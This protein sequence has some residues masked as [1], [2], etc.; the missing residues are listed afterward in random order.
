MKWLG[1]AVLALVLLALAGILLLS[2][3]DLGRFKSTIESEASRLGGR[4]VTINGPVHIGLSLSPTLVAEKITVANAGW[5]S[6]PALATAEHAEIRVALL[7]LFQGRVVPHLIELDGATLDLENDAKGRANWRL[8]GDVPSIDGKPHESAAATDYPALFSSLGTVQVSRLDV[9]YHD[10]RTRVVTTMK[11]DEARFVPDAS[12]VEI[13]LKGTLD[14]SLIALSGVVSGGEDRTAFDN[15]SFTSGKTSIHGNLV[16]VGKPETGYRLDGKLSGNEFDLTPIFDDGADKSH[17]FGRTPLPFG[18]LRL[19]D[20]DLVVEAARLNYR[21]LAFSNVSAPI[22]I[23]RGKLTAPLKGL[24][25]GTDVSFV[26]TADGA[27]YMAGIEGRS[28]G[29]DLGSLLADLKLTTLVAAKGDFALKVSGRG[30]SVH[31]IA[32]TLNGQ[33]EVAASDGTIGTRTFELVASDLSRLIIPQGSSRN[34]TNLACFLSRFDFRDGMGVS[35]AFAFQTSDI[36]TIGRGG[37]DLRAETVD[38]LLQPKPLDPSLLSLSTP[39]RVSGR[40]DDPQIGLDTFGL[41]QK[42]AEVAGSAALTGG[43]GAILPLVSFGNAAAK[44]GNCASLVAEAAKRGGIS[45][46]VERG[47]AAAGGAVDSAI[48]GV[49][50]FFNEIGKGIGKVLK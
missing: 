27:S 24:Y 47:G 50:S 21:G 7:P 2:T 28:T 20:A 13:E 36:I 23:V 11:L 10:A 31:D 16:L 26:V 9:R 25:R 40:L 38:M 19:I 42:V 17:V 29:F 37:L 1:R 33:T 6:A 4:T 49:G 41:A 35:K 3:I 15:A 14:G 18:L 34:S 30:P 44:S 39:I 32:S 46:V 48:Q 43:V 5:A 8:G 45:G 22:H 12:S